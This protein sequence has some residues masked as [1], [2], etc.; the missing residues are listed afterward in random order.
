M[1]QLQFYKKNEEPTNPSEGGVWFDSTNKQIKLKTSDG[2]DTYSGLLNPAGSINRPIYI[3]DS[4]KA[5]EVSN[6]SYVMPGEIQQ[7]SNVF[8]TKSGVWIDDL[9]NVFF[10]GHKRL[11]SIST[12]GTEISEYQLDYIFHARNYESSVS[13]AKSSTTVITLTATSP[14]GYIFQD[15]LDYGYLVLNFYYTGVPENI[16]VRI[17]CNWEPHGIGWHDLPR[18]QYLEYSSYDNGRFIFRNDYHQISQIEIT[19]TA[20]DDIDT[21]LTSIQWFLDRPSQLELTG[22]NKS[23]DNTF[24]GKLITY[25]GFIKKGATADQVLCGD[26]SVKNISDLEVNKANNLTW[27]MWQ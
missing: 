22:V 23:G 14:T 8:L 13:L 19:I 6:L 11:F 3:D 1:A 4:G 5:V 12:T 10:L 7:R 20:K 2:W 24:Y 17:Y 21:Q 18:R 16:S 25:S 27:E 9:H 15:D 26:G